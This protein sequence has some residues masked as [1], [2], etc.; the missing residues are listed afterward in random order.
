MFRKSAILAVAFAAATLVTDAVPA[1]AIPIPPPGGN[2]LTV[3]AY[4]SD[5][6]KTQLVGQ[7]WSGCGQPSGSWGIT[8]PNRNLFFP[9]C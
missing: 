7:T 6:S 2:T 5:A 4:Y 3:I 9:A 8:T 1:H